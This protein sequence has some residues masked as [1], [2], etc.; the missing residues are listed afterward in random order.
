MLHPRKS[1]FKARI[2]STHKNITEGSFILVEN[3]AH[4]GE[5]IFAKPLQKENFTLGIPKEKIL[6]NRTQNEE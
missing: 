6:K 3:K 1:L 2:A 5:K 4:I